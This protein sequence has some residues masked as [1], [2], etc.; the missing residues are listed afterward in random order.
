[1]SITR[2]DFLKATGLTLA[3]AGLAPFAGPQLL[4][5]TS[6]KPAVAPTSGLEIG[7]ASY[8]LRKYKLDEV[9]KI[10]KR[11]NITQISLK[12]MHLPLNSTP[13][14][15]TEAIGKLKAAGI[16]AYGCG[17]VY[18]KNEEEVNRTFEYAKLAGFKM[19]V[20]VP[21]PELLPLVE[22]KVKETNIMV[23][24]H[25]HG[26]GD[27][28]YPSP[29]DV[30]AKIKDLDKRIGMCI[31]IGHTQRIGQDP[32]KMVTKYA[33]RLYDMHFKDVTGNTAKDTPT[34]V[35]RGVI[36]IPGFLKALKKINYKGV[37]ALEYEKDG[38]EPISGTGESIGYVRGLLKMMS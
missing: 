3:A 6:A 21:S 12:D 36:D 38:D 1:M 10:A 31:D 7:L 32:V 29:D 33:D 17:V 24:I 9:I 15:I 23:A 35:G 14:Q 27:K 8:T 5:E 20:G 19:I 13:E 11:L 34:E 28:I 2:K 18:M 37:V 25:N 16:T 30:Y 26:P 4:A 22:K